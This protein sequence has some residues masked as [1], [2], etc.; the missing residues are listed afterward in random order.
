MSKNAVISREIF[1]SVYTQ[2]TEVQLCEQFKLRDSLLGRTLL[3]WFPE[4]CSLIDYI[5]FSNKKT[6]RFP[7]FC[8]IWYVWLINEDVKPE[9]SLLFRLAP[10]S[11][12]YGLQ[13]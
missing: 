2:K 12:V 7:L 10:Q 5:I 13:I 6:G 4:V 8:P 1:K 3:Y 9:L 11:H